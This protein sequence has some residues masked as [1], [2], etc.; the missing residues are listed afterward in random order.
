M[1]TRWKRFLLA[2]FHMNVLMEQTSPRQVLKI[3]ENLPKEVND[4]YNNI[5]GRIDSLRMASEIKKFIAIT[6][7]V[8][9]PLHV[10]ELEQACAV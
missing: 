10:A 2:K 8:R 7:Y 4:I 9:R 6:A 1:L 3:L 5:F